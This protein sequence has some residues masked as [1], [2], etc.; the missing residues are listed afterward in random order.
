M[1]RN[2][3]QTEA[4]VEREQLEWLAKIS[5]RHED[6]L[7]RLQSAEGKARRQHEH[8]EWLAKISP[9]YE[10]ELRRPFNQE[11]EAS[12]DTQLHE[13]GWDP[14]KHPRLGA[15]PNAGW[16]ASTGGTG[17][18]GAWRSDTATPSSDSQ[19]VPAHLASWHPPV[20]NHWVPVGVTQAPDIRPFLSDCTF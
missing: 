10:R 3:T 17:G 15:A 5:P 8:L 18:I 20:G 6:E 19:R 13:A 7:R 2:V 12:K 14:S 1:N 4:S 16:F 9:N 11:A